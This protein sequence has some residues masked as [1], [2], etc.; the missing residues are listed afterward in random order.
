VY[1]I[2]YEWNSSLKSR[3]KKLSARSLA[4]I[5]RNQERLGTEAEKAV[6]EYEKKVLT[7]FPEL[8]SKIVHLA[9]DDVGAGYDVYSVRPC[10]EGGY[11]DRF[12]EVKAV[13]S[14]IDFYW[15]INE[16][17][18]AKSLGMEYHLYLLPVLGNGQFDF[19]NLV[20]ISDPYKDLFEQENVRK[21]ESVS[22]HVSP[23]QD[24]LLGKITREA[25]K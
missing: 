9:L 7:S 6:I 24:Y 13:S 21:M 23:E 2:N 19:D 18:T 22:F 1:T 15:S 10:E 25:Q 8:A 16:V 4:A 17:N 11:E 5:L 14:D 3:H 20:V 12:I